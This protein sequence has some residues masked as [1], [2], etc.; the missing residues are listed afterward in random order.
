M[1]S[2]AIAAPSG[3]WTA[4]PVEPSMPELGAAGAPAPG[5]GGREVRFQETAECYFWLFEDSPLAMYVCDA[6]GK[7]TEV[8]SALCRL[9]DRQPEDIIGQTMGGFSA[10]PL[11]SVTELEDFLEGRA[12]TFSSLRHYRASDGRVLPVRVTLGAVRDGAGRARRIFGEVED[13]TAQYVAGEELDRQRRRLEI[14]I[15]ASGIAIWE[16]DMTSGLVTVEDRAGAA[17]VRPSRQGRDFGHGSMTYATFTRKFHIDDRRYFPPLRE[18]RSQPSL[19]LDADLRVGATTGPLRW[20]HVKGKAF[21]SDDGRVARLVGTIVDVTEARTA[22]LGAER[23]LSRTLEASL[24]AFIGL[25]ELGVVTDWNPVAEAMFGWFHDEV[26][27][28]DLGGLICSPE[29]ADAL[30]RLLGDLEDPGSAGPEGSGVRCELGAKSRDGRLFPVEVSVVR[31]EDGGVPL[32]RLFVRDLSERKAYEDQ[33]VRNALFDSLT[34]LPNRALLM[35]RLG[36]A[37]GRLSRLAGLLAV[38]FIDVDRFKIVN[39]S[40]GRRAGDDFLVQLGHRLRAVL[41]PADTV[42]RL[43]GDEFVVLCESLDGEREAMALAERVHGVL[44]RPFALAGHHGQEIY[45]SVSVGVAL[46]NG[47]GTT[48]EALVREAEIAMRRAKEQGGGRAEVFDAESQRRSIAHLETEAQLRRALERSELCV[49]YQPMVDLA[50]E[51]QEVEALVRWAHPS[52]RVALPSEFV[53]LAEET[54]LIVAVG[55]LVLRMACDQAAQWRRTDPRL[56]R[57]RV[58]VN[59]STAQLRRADAVERMVSIIEA[60]GLPPSALTL[61]I[62]ESVLMDEKA[63]AGSKLATLR[64]LG[65]RLAIDD[66]GTGYS[67]LLYL[68]RYP[69]DILKI[70]RSFVAGLVDNPEDA[71]IVDAVVRLGHSFGLLTVAEGVETAEQLALLHTLE[72]DMVQGYLWGRPEPPELLLDHVLGGLP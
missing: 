19:E 25:D 49:Y 39:D 69:L 7:V 54:G 33:L 68:R 3:D 2:E 45:A 51:L 30:A 11:L 66:F 1:S 17:S 38:L 44:A 24:D 47:A 42:A 59:V 71:A 67:S 37:I 5:S 52:G 12:R 23:V 61:E 13:L 62:T 36:G 15:E 65:V 72:C 48:S 26:V 40:L 29:G 34:G 31:I 28:R 35:D 32:F 27:G 58:S 10:D 43:G 55:E 64:S 46:T 63:G 20:V 16:L 57:L 8:N 21:P 60:T 9:L 22:R 4:Q 18:L 6:E 53:P 50:G 41:R 70:D 14:A 56:A